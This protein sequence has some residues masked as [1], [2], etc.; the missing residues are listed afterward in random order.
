MFPAGSAGYDL[1]V[2]EKLLPDRIKCQI[3]INVV[4]ISWYTGR[5][6]CFLVLSPSNELETSPTG[7]F[8][9]QRYI[10]AMSLELI[11]RRT[12]A[13]IGVVLDGIHRRH[14]PVADPDQGSRP[15]AFAHVGRPGLV[16]H[17][18]Q[19]HRLD[20]K[21]HRTTEGRRVS[22]EDYS[23]QTTAVG[24]RRAPDAGHAGRDRNARQPAAAVERIAFD[25]GHAGRDCH[26]RQPAAVGERRAPDAG[27][28]GRDRHARQPAAASERIHSNDGHA[29]RDR[30][31]RQPT[32]ASERIAPNDGHA[33][34]DRHASQSAAVFERTPPSAGHALWNR[35]ARQPAAAVERIIFYNSHTRWDRNITTSA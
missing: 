7:F 26:T 20:I 34:R 31:A 14:V 35:H 10:Y 30:H 23:L 21:K 15:V 32:A 5:F 22:L 28:A 1:F 24:E 33:L 18:I 17:R 2:G 9:G 6:R 8:T 12:V 11:R 29:L 4:V 25:A 19:R 16:V 27:H 3:G 13:A